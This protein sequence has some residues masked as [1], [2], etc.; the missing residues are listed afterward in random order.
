M[1]TEKGRKR[2]LDKVIATIRVASLQGKGVS[3]DKIRA[4][5]SLEQGVTDRKAKEYIEILLRAEVIV[6]KGDEL[7]HK[8][9]LETLSDASIT[10]SDA[11]QSTNI[12]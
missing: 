9:A 2:M 7:W 1:G 8:E 12:S 3:D 4:I 5:I 6:R 11:L 10:L